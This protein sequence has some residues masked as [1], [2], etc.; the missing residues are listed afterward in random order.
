MSMILSISPLAPP[1]LKSVMVS[2]PKFCSR[3]ENT[4]VSLPAS[5][6]SVSFSP[7]PKITSFPGVPVRLTP[8]WPKTLKTKL[9]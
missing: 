5:P 6:V 4:K 3:N 9:T 8:G 7:V 1:T 2:V